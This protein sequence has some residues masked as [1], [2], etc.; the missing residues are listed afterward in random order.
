[1][2]KDQVEETLHHIFDHMVL[3][4]HLKGLACKAS[5]RYVLKKGHSVRVADQIV[6]KLFH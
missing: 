1:M 3:N 4:Q 5:R 2:T 6:D